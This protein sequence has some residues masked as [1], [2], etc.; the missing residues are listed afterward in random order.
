MNHL[1]KYFF[2]TLILFYSISL[3]AETDISKTS[4]KMKITVNEDANIRTLPDINSDIIKV[5]K[6]GTSYTGTQSDINP[7]WYKIEINGKDGFIHSSVIS[8]TEKKDSSSFSSL[9]PLIIIILIIYEIRKKKKVSHTSTPVFEKIKNRS[10]KLSEN[11]PLPVVSHSPVL[12]QN[13]EICHYSGKAQQVRTKNVI[14]GHTGGG[15][16]ISTRIMKGVYL[17]TGKTTSKAIRADVQETS[18]GIISITNKRIIFSGEKWSF[19]KSIQ[20]L[21]SITPYSDALSL[22]FGSTQYTILIGPAEYVLSILT[23]II[24]QTN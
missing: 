13:G 4:A 2:I 15:A 7:N 17:K 16:G 9:I 12:L 24:N 21:S 3:F 23:R 20:S 5:A 14:V 1:K 10:L 19:D 22:Q 11:D 6:K 8:V 18:D